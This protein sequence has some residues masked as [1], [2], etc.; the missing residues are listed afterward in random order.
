MWG[1]RSRK[2][3]GGPTR[4][5]ALTL[6]RWEQGEIFRYLG[7]MAPLQPLFAEIAELLSASG[8]AEVLQVCRRCPDLLTDRGDAAL[9]SVL[10]YAEMINVMLFL[11]VMR[12]RQQ[13]LRHLREAEVRPDRLRPPSDE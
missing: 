8:P 11:P 5:D 4:E 1:R 10:L 6:L 12:D 9:E 3:G 2:K 7:E 13:W